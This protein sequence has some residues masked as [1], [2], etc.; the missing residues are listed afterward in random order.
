MTRFA[1]AAIGVLVIAAVAWWAWPSGPG[2]EADASYTTEAIDRGDITQVVSAVGS[3]RA[4]NSVEVGSQ[5][6]G[7]LEALFVDYNRS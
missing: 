7:Q 1:A 2:S 4:R 5:R 3:V 6:S